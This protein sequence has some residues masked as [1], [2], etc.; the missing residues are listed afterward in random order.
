M[1]KGYSGYASGVASH[2][3][4][5]LSI[6][7]NSN[8]QKLSAEERVFSPPPSCNGYYC[9][10]LIQCSIKLYFFLNIIP[11]FVIDSYGNHP[12]AEAN[13]NLFYSL[14]GIQ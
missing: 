4:T 2:R 9:P 10:G 3:N 11:I 1:G 12:S 7:R 14:R 5:L 6:K 8:H 13:D